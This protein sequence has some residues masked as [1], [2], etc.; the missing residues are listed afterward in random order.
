MDYGAEMKLNG[1]PF[2]YRNIKPHLYEFFC[3]GPSNGY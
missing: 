3:Y 2:S 1:A